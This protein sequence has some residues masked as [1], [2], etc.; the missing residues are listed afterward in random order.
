MSQVS[1]FCISHSRPSFIPKSCY[2]HLPKQ[3]LP[4]FSL[5]L[6]ATMV[7]ALSLI[8][9]RLSSSSISSA[10]SADIK[11]CLFANISMGSPASLSSSNS[12]YNSSP[13]SS[14]LP[15]SDESITNIYT[16]STY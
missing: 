2:K 10:G 7:H 9:D 15:L 13:H 14:I 1:M 6:Q 5:A 4:S 16:V 12:F 11:S 3:S 8:M